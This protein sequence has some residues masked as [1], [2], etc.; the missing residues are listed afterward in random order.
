MSVEV[1]VVS[2]KGFKFTGLYPSL[3]SRDD[4]KTNIDEQQ[5]DGIG[6][7]LLKDV[8]DGVKVWPRTIA[9]LGISRPVF[10]DGRRI[11]DVSFTPT[12]NNILRG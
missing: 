9:R 3:P 7:V 11:G 12:R 2:V 5:L 1:K 10:T 6:K 4:V 8:V